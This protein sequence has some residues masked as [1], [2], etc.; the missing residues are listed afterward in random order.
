MKKLIGLIMAILMLPAVLAA[1][2]F[3]FSDVSL[4][5]ENQ[6]RG[7]NVSTSVTLTNTGTD[8]LSGF[9][10]NGINSKYNLQIDG[11]PTSLAAGDTA[12]ITVTAFVPFDHDAVDNS[13]EETALSIGTLTIT[14]SEGASE[15]QE[16]KLQAVNELRILDVKAKIDGEKQGSIEGKIIDVY[17]DADVE[18]EVEIKNR[19]SD[20]NDIEG[21]DQEIDVEIKVDGDTDELDLDE[22]SDDVSADDEIKISLDGVVEDD[23][24][25]RIKLIL[26]AEGKDE[27][28]AEH[29]DE[30]VIKFRVVDKPKIEEE[31]EPVPAFIPLTQE[32]EQK[33]PVQQIQEEKITSA[34]ESEA[35]PIVLAVER[36]PYSGPSL[37]V[38]ALLGLTIIALVGGVAQI[39][40]FKRKSRKQGKSAPLERYQ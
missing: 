9:S 23:A 22:D 17:E 11:F 30:T 25:G 40:W 5:S 13:C 1:A 7:Q 34:Q 15:S 6:N 31:K 27:R 10:F 12:D 33:P 37:Y 29:C 14:T 20:D 24:R 28:G 3:T 2:D 18:V 35:A 21:Q 38:I 16:I 8:T 26:T 39:I 4:G 36:Q 19:F 32:A